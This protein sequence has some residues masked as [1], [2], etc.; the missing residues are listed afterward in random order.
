MS[1]RD[2]IDEKFDGL[3]NELRAAR[4]VAPD[5]LRQRV[6]A[7][8]ARPPVPQQRLRLR[9]VLAPS[10]AALVA[11]A[12]VIGV[13]SGG[14]EQPQ[15]LT[16]PLVERAATEESADAGLAASGAPIT[17]A[18]RAQL[19]SAEIALR[20]K[21]LSDVTQDALRQTRALGGYVRRVD[22]GEGRGEGTAR[23]VVRVPIERVQTAILRFSE[24]GKIL[25]QHVSVRDVQ[26]RLDRRFK[27]IAELQRLI[28]SLSGDE[29][30]AA[31]AELEALR[32]AQASDR[33]RT[34]FA[35]VALELTTQAEEAVPASP[36]RIERA[37]E[38]AVDVLAAEAVALVYATVVAAPFI[39]LAVALFGLVRVMKRRSDERL[40][41]Y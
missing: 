27:R 3:V 41:G 12:I 39:V 26:P 14:D 29:L 37:F 6:A 1:S 23:I 18:N 11:G 36:G 20:V 9:W 13:V 33:Q 32:A 38:R 5:H 40:L 21:D 17:P 7:I 16:T 10:A 24:L 30:A 19:Y 25:D 34:S 2:L 35:T 15:Q 22:Y 4:P 28:P 31:Q 8:A